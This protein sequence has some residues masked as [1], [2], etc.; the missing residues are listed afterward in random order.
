MLY[1]I[2]VLIFNYYFYLYLYIAIKVNYQILYAVL[3]VYFI[4]R[5]KGKEYLTRFFLLF[6]NVII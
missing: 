2:L 3:F 5:N 1:N 4:S 6:Y